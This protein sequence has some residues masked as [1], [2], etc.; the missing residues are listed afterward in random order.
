MAEEVGSAG[1]SAEV[2]ASVEGVPVPMGSSGRVV[3]AVEAVA[4]SSVGAIT[5][6]AVVV[7]TSAV[8]EE[9]IG[10][11]V[12]VAGALVVVVVVACLVVVV[13]VVAFVVVVVVVGA[14]F[15]L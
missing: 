10:L 15:L 3:V 5:S 12:V 4:V 1:V 2:G 9:A 6:V 11:P 8:V 14:G 7:G 13:V